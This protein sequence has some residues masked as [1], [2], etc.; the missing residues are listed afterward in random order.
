MSGQRCQRLDSQLDV[1]T[2][3]AKSISCTVLVECRLQTEHPAKFT[4]VTELRTTMLAGDN[5][6][7]IH[8]FSQVEI[9]FFE[10]EVFHEVPLSGHKRASLG[11]CTFQCSFV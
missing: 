10:A 4:Q 3:S 8:L 1:S 5:G 2:N 6:W 11:K 7:T 9:R